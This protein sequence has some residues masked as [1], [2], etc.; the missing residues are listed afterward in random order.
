MK[1][2]RWLVGWFILAAVLSSCS[3]LKNAPQQFTS[4]AGRF[5]IMTQQ[6]FKESTEQMTVS[7]IQL[8]YHMFTAE[9]STRTDLVAYT[10]YPEDVVSK[11]DPAKILD[12]ASSGAVKNINGNL[13][14]KANITL[15][16]NP[17][18][19]IV[20]DAATADGQAYMLKGR[21]YL[22]KNRL[23]MVLMVSN[24]GDLTQDQTD[25]FLGSFKL[26]Q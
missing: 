4:D 8:D 26:L 1:K 11:S 17:G 23:Y 6:S 5:T 21:I 16:G 13:V 25:A 7:G 10:D 22:V 18:R 15:D 9:Q 12:G 24:K 19:E 14:S 20:A 3:A 2:C